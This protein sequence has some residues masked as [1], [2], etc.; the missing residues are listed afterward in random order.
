MK[1]IKR[2]KLL[3]L[4][5]I[6]LMLPLAVTVCSTDTP[7]L[8]TVK[9]THTPPTPNSMDEVTIRATANPGDRGVTITS[10]VM[11]WALDGEP[12]EYV[13]MTRFNLTDFTGRIPLQE[14]GTVVEYTI[15][16]T[17]NLGIKERVSGTYTVIRPPIE[18]RLNEINRTPA[19]NY[20]EL[21][22]LTSE[23]E[24][25]EDFE[26]W[27][28]DESGVR[29]LLWTGAS[30]VEILP[31][32][33][34]TITGAELAYELSPSQR[35]TIEFRDY[36][37]NVLDTY[38]RP[39]NDTDMNA[40]FGISNLFNNNMGSKRIPDG[41]GPWYFFSGAG[42][43][44][45]TNGPSALG[46]ITG[47]PGSAFLAPQSPHFWLRLNELNG[48]IHNNS[49]YI[50]L[51]NMS[52]VPISLNGI[53]IWTFDPGG[54]PGNPFER[55]TLGTAADGTIAADGYFTFI[56]RGD[57]PPPY[58]R[59]GRGLSSSRAITV[60]LKDADG[61]I[62]DRYNRAR[63]DVGM[64]TLVGIPGLFS[65]SMGSKRIPDGIGSWYFF[66]GSDD[67]GDLGSPGRA[68]PTTPAGLIVDHPAL[69]I[70]VP[71]E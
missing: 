22:N 41:T 4:L 43:P 40:L 65:S 42:S 20:I 18:I 9:A 69:V 5:L 29:R 46:L 3:G 63:G 59:L 12:Q 52:T 11:E 71:Y 33:F 6:P 45:A 17:N 47:H 51:F 55:I 27:L 19:N 28:T 16:V 35:M 2:I 26:I 30:G 10:V 38:N 23:T 31:G 8:P 7:P 32:E 44:G 54:F 15:V 48:V 58:N 39:G 67:D 36:A 50:E 37:G 24:S 70:S 57:R 61:R 49:I 62:I 64:N 13:T 34:F 66:S 21:F 56:G 68:N 1:N 14:I 53:E 60:T 25:L